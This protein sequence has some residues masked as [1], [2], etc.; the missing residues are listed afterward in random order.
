M[1][2][3]HK[4]TP[5]E[6]A[7]A[8]AKWRAS[9]LMAHLKAL[10]SDD[11]RTAV[12]HVAHLTF[13]VGVAANVDKVP[14]TNTDLRII[15]GTSNTLLDVAAYEQLTDMQRGS[16][17]AGLLAIERLH[18]QL[19]DHAMTIAELTFRALMGRGGIYGKH[20]QEVFA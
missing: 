12:E 11:W 9:T 5:V 14:R 1:R 7:I 13:M 20:F 10:D 2:R 19:S 4:L 16:M 8:K 18:P 3:K 15:A 6:K 17:S